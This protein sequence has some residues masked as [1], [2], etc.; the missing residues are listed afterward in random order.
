MTTFGN[1]DEV[2]ISWLGGIENVRGWSIPTK[3]I[4]K[5]VDNKFRFGN[6]SAVF[7]SELRQTIIPTKVLSNE[8]MN[9]KQEYGLTLIGFLDLGFTS[10]IKEDLFNNLPMIG[11]GFGFRIPFPMI[12]TVGLDYGWGYRHANFIDQALHLTVGQKF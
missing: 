2:F 9:W 7:S 6:H 11:M 3:S 1:V 4:Y 12:G 8:L 10:R 5:N